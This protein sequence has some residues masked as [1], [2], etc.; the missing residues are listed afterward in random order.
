MMLTET[1]LLF[2]L[3]YPIILGSCLIGFLFGMYNW[4]QVKS[5]DT[6]KRPEDKNHILTAG[7]K[8][9]NGEHID[10]LQLMNKTSILIQQ[11]PILNKSRVP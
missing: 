2:E 8:R 1:L 11:V 5:I 9:E 6:E 3:A 4:S 10:H 7:S